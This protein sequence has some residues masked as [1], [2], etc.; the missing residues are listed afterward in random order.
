M[1]ISNYSSMQFTMERYKEPGDGSI[2][3][4]KM[5]ILYGLMVGDGGAPGSFLPI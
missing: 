2:S 3:V 1:R 5:D 4:L